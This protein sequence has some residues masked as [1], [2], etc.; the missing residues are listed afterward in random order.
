MNTAKQKYEKREKNYTKLLE[1][2]KKAEKVIS[3]LRLGVFA[4]GICAIVLA[5][6]THYYII[7]AVAFALLTGFFIYLAIQHER[8]IVRTRYT[9][10]LLKINISSLKRI[11]GEWNKFE[12][13]GED[14]V[15][16]N[17]NYSGDLDV[18]GKNSLFQCINTAKTFIG[19]EM[20][21]DLLSGVIGNSDDVRERQEAV[22]EL[23]TKLNWRQ[24]F[25][26]EGMVTSEKIHNPEELIAWGQE[27]KP[28]FLKT[29]VIAILRLCPV[30][31]ILLIT[32]GFIMNL[33]PLYI[34]AT[35]LLIQFGLISYRVRERYRM[36]GL[37]ETYNEDL[38]VYY[39]MLKLLEKGRFKSMSIN[40]IKD[41]IR[42]TAK[43]EAFRQLDKLSTI[44]DS[45]SNR[46]NMFYIIFNTLTLWDYQSIIAFERWKKESGHLL[47]DW[48]DTVGKIEAL[49]SLAVIGYENPDW[50]MPLLN[51][52]TETVFEAKG[53]GHPLITGRRVHNDLTVDLKVKVILVTGSNMSG[54]STL[55]RTAG[56]NLVLAYAGA[57]VCARTFEAS[58][59]EI[60]TCMR[61]KDNIEESIS[62]FYAELL[63]I[64]KIVNESDSGKR[65]FFLLDE[66]FKGTNSQDRHTGAKVLINK[67]SRTNSIGLIS[68]H[69]LELCDLE[70]EN[71]K[72]ANYH[73]QEYYE[74]GK[75][76]F[77]YKLRQGP[78]TTRNA[79]HLMKLAGIDVL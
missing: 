9:N 62:S 2:Q 72:V 71:D 60:C 70:Q 25:E 24:R 75:I 54:K 68:T 3:N 15:D 48:F 51:E 35:A 39:K 29:W 78:S 4:A 21:R 23:A 42:N 28:F 27:H 74:D 34:P 41:S 36:F 49:A 37:F 65:V 14:F 45:I 63:R 26:A 11:K 17:H 76:N 69:D 18:F 30:A 61:I 43:F 19:R 12:D 31:T 58:M 64:K 16:D 32:A 57:P 40:K 38:R 10:L 56:I 46:R 66:I 7:F 47:K 8:L 33:I 5:Y 67:L 79:L 20:L 6:I 52:K 59:M 22:S 53:L 1:A 44:V 77:D 55:L 73:F 50:T 13:S